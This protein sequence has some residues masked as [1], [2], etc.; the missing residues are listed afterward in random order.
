MRTRA[1]ALAAAESRRDAIKAISSR[2]CSVCREVT[3]QWKELR[4]K[5]PPP[6][7]T[8]PYEREPEVSGVHQGT[9]WQLIEASASGCGICAAVEA[10]LKAFFGTVWKYFYHC[11]DGSTHFDLAYRTIRLRGGNDDTSFSQ[12]FEAV[13]VPDASLS[14]YKGLQESYM[15]YGDVLD[16]G[17][18]WFQTCLERHEECGTVIDSSYYPPRLLVIDSPGRVHLVESKD[19]DLG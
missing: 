8:G 5:G 7:N 9:I 17:R 11:G 19:L 4:A 10:N 6:K 1:R 16:R 3:R 13:P 18:M 15:G 12:H 14:L 2:L